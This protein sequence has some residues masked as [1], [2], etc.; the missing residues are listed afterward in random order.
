MAADLPHTLLRRTKTGPGKVTQD[1]I[2]LATEKMR[3]A[4]ERRKKREEEEKKKQNNPT[5][6]DIFGGALEE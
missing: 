4:Y 6:E 3:L 5:V 1:D 2:D